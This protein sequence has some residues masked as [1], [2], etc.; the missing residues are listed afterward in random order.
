MLFSDVL[1]SACVCVLVLLLAVYPSLA[2][3]VVVNSPQNNSSVSSPVQYVASAHNPNCP[4][5]IVD[6]RIY[7]AP[8]IAPYNVQAASLNTAL[9]LAPGNYKTVVQ[10]WDACGGVSKT[11]VS[12]T[13]VAPGLKPVR[14]LYVADTNFWRVFG[15]Q[16]NPMT[17]VPTATPQVKISF[18]TGVVP[19]ALASD[20]GGYRLYVSANGLHAYFIDRRNGNLTEAP[21][22]PVSV[23]SGVGPLAVHPSGKFVFTATFSDASGAGLLI[24]HVNSDGSLSSVNSTPVP[25]KD[26][27]RN[28]IIDRSGK[29]LY[30]LSENG[31]SIDAFNIDGNSGNL[32]PLPGSPYVMTKPATGCNLYP[33]GCDTT[34]ISDD[35]GRFLYV[36]EAFGQAIQGFSIT[37]KTGTLSNVAGSPFSSGYSLTTFVEPTGRF[38]YVTNA[39]SQQIALFSIDAGSGMLTHVKD[40]GPSG[41]VSRLRGDPSGKFLYEGGGSLSG[42]AIDSKTGNLSPMPGSPFTMGDNVTLYEFVL[43]P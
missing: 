12:F 34:D 11:P 13:I 26:L 3:V 7:I 21:D 5:G 8:H 27:L 30:A 28:V 41:G 33:F 17:G 42:F 39:V 37:G 19:V 18:P 16:V 10:A 15:F 25:V 29:Y 9:A 2:Q 6:M 23:A 40:F 22:S 20:A 43:T 35:N 36:A 32:T 4:K 1:G 31:D 14:F 38:L 24:F